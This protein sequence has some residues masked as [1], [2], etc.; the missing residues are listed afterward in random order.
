M[1]K[2]VVF[3]VALTI[4]FGFTASSIAEIYQATFKN[5]KVIAVYP[6]K[7]A[8]KVKYYEVYFPDDFPP[9]IDKTEVVKSLVINKETFYLYRG[10]F[11]LKSFLPWDLQRNNDVIVSLDKKTGQIKFELK[12]NYSRH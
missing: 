7:S 5:G 9:K 10:G 6:K 4:F 8:L 12:K 1:K 11:R 2:T 3:L